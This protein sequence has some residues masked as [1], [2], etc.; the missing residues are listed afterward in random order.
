[1]WENWCLLGGIFVCLPILMLFKE[2]YNRLDIDIV[3][4]DEKYNDT[5]SEWA[6]NR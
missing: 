6:Y 3:V 1:M 2:H 5:H 4:D